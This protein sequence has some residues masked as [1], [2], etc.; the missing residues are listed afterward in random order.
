MGGLVGILALMFHSLVERN[1]QVPS[2]AFLYT[3]LWGVVLNISL[4]KRGAISPGAY[5]N[6]S[7]PVGRTSEYQNIREEDDKFG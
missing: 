5:Q 6:T 4:T 1:I 3:I 7:V 2:N